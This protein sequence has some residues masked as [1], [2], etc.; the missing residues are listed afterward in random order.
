[1]A[2]LEVIQRNEQL[3]IAERQRVGRLVEK[4]EKIKQRAAE[5]GPRYCR[6]VKPFFIHVSVHSTY[7]NSYGNERKVWKF[8]QTSKYLCLSSS[9]PLQA[10]RSIF[11]T[12]GPVKINL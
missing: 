12:V 1:M 10:L 8:I 11:W 4:V 5:C 7:I 9:S 6:L 3:E 2:I